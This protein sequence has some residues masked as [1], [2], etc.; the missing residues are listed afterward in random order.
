M[1]PR[2][3]IV[4]FDHS[5]QHPLEEASLKK[6]K[7]SAELIKSMKMAGYRCT[8]IKM[9]V[10]SHDLTNLPGFSKL[11]NH[12]HLSKKTL[13]DLANVRNLRT[14]H[15]RSYKVCAAEM[16]CAKCAAEMVC[17]YI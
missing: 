7:K 8:P 13:K 11:K 17:V 3:Q 5:F 9:E 12:F 1:K 15:L 10:G 6:K 16:A 14:G 4:R 2:E